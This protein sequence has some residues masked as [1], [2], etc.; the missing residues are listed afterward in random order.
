M[1]RGL[2]TQSSS[3]RNELAYP[4]TLTFETT[5]KISK[6]KSTTSRVSQ[7]HSLYQVWDHSFL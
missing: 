5:S 3:M 4:L 2:S 6:T 7:S 1:N